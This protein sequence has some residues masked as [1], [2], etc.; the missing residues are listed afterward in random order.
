MKKLIALLLTL[1]FMT[2]GVCAETALPAFMTEMY[3]NYTTD[4]KITMTFDSGEELAALLD[5]LELPQEFSYFVDVK[6]LLR[7]LL[8]YESSMTLQADIS[9]NLDVYDIALTM[10]SVH[11]IDVNSN[12]QIGMNA[13]TG[14]W[15][16]MDLS[17]A[18]AI[19]FQFIYALPIMDKYFIVS[20]ED[21]VG[22]EMAVLLREM[23]N[24]EMINVMNEL[25]V[26]LL[27][28]YAT[29][30]NSGSTY[31]L[32]MDNAAFM[33]YLEAVMAQLP[34]LMP[35]VTEEAVMTDAQEEIELLVAMS[36]E[37]EMPSFADFKVLGDEG[38]QCVYTVKNDKISA[39][40]ATA[41]IA[42]NLAEIYKAST[43]LDWYYEATG[44]LDF[45]F[46]M[47]A[48]FS[49]FGNTK[50]EFPELTEENSFSMDKIMENA[51]PEV[52]LWETEEEITYP[53]WIVE[54][55]EENLPFIDGEL[56]VPLRK[57]LEAA[58]G[59]TVL[60][61][62]QNGVITATCPH[63]SEFATL[64]LTVGSDKAYTDGTEHVVGAI[65][66]QND[67]TYVKATFFEKV[68]GW[69][70]VSADHNLMENMYYCTFLT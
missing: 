19:D 6:A 5:E 17:D 33:G 1:L 46:T 50:V 45:T 38:L 2:T 18:E 42:L 3:T 61:D 56:Y 67:T 48:T 4:Y 15:I 59:E 24:P 54:L 22:Q 10:D 62:Y 52:G 68:L 64:T 51:E 47:S 63:F 8:A 34:A 69:M 57:S 55:Y 27:A 23:L 9:E 20:S 30:T 29:V 41:D 65:L 28:E 37:Y 7:S 49:D 40:T 70:L 25:S 26:K 44:Q 66:L 11:D 12:L 16:H 14:M 32:S 58:Y 13:K 60:I 31:T 21:A 35:A 36:P 39:C 53:A 43:G